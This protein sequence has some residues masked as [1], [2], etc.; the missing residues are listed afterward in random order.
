MSEP[1]PTESPREVLRARVALAL[2]AGG[3]G[4]AAAYAA[5][6]TYIFLRVGPMQPVLVVRTAAIA[7]YH[8]L[9]VAAVLGVAWGL[10]VLEHLREPARREPFERALERAVLPILA[11]S[12]AA[13]WL[14]P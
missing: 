2:V 4:C 11:A 7:Y 12:V 1:R 6:R 9:G 3:L 8:A 10:F 13:C 14:F 5:V